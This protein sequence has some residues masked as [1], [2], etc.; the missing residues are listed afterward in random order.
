MKKLNI[1]IVHVYR[2]TQTQSVLLKDDGVYVEL[3]RHWGHNCPSC[4][5]TQGSVQN[6]LEKKGIPWKFMTEYG[7]HDRG[8]T[9]VVLSLP[10][11]GIDVIDYVR[12]VLEI[13]VID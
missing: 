10:P 13:P 8:T 3:Q 4:S 5:F 2:C 7:D 11:E 1:D 9:F 12:G 6:L